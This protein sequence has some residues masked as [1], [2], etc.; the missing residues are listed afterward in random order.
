MKI[1]FLT[2][3]YPPE[4]GASQ[5]RLSGLAAALQRRGHAVTV[6]TAKPNYPGGRTHAGYPGLVHREMRDGVPVLRTFIYPTQKADFLRRTFSYC[7]FVL[8]SAV[9]G[10]FCLERP[11]YLIVE[12]PPL[13][14]GLA[15]IWL[16]W[17]KR[18]PMIFNVSDLWPESAVRLGVLRAGSVSH[19]LST[20]PE[21]FC[22]RRA[23][24]V[25]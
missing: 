16:S 3:Y 24:L 4:I 15:G 25:T 14:L 9:V 19:R 17:V 7:S 22:Y 11:D 21:R 10:T 20:W 8:A 1:A 23:V 6:L 18:C 5:A 2:Q 13:L 12:S